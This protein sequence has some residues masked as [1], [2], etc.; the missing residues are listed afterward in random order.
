MYCQPR[1]VPERRQSLLDDMPGRHTIANCGEPREPA[2]GRSTLGIMFHISV[3]CRAQI[4]AER[5]A[6]LATKETAAETIDRGRA[7][8]VLAEDVATRSLTEI[9]LRIRSTV[10]PVEEKKTSWKDR[11]E[12]AAVVE[13]PLPRPA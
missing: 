4:K 1:R 8:M 13:H 10:V 11:E 3:Y 2:P 12:V 5:I 6:A 7:V 9:A